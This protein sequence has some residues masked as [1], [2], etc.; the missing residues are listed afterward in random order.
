MTGVLLAFFAA[1]AAACAVLFVLLRR[2]IPEEGLLPWVRESFAARHEPREPGE[3]GPGTQQDV[4]VSELMG[5]A[6][7][8][9]A[10][11]RPVDLGSVAKLRS[12]T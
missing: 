11:H 2:Q 4:G 6:E 10:Y 9:P 3:G 8:G 1:V 5:L 7:D 12:R